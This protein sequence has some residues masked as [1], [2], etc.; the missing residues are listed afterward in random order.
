M[1]SK[2]IEKQ[3][4]DPVS[5][6]IQ[7]QTLATG[8]RAYLSSPSDRARK[9]LYHLAIQL[10]VDAK[11]NLLHSSVT[12]ILHLLLLL[13][14]LLRKQKNYAF[15]EQCW[16]RRPRHDFFLRSWL[17]T[18]KKSGRSK[19]GLQALEALT[20]TYNDEYLLFERLA[21][22]SALCNETQKEF[23]AW[24]NAVRLDPQNKVAAT[25]LKKAA[26]K[27]ALGQEREKS[28]DQ[29]LTQD[30]D[31]ISLRMQWIDQRVN[32]REYREA[33]AETEAYISAQTTP[34]PRL[35]R[36]LYLL[37]EHHLNFQLAQA[38]DARNK[39]SID[40]LQTE[41]E[42]L[43]I[44]RLER[45]VQ[46]DQNN[47]QYRYDLGKALLNGRRWQAAITQ[48]EFASH[49]RNRRLRSLIYLS[50]AYLALDQ[51]E[52]AR[53]QL[54]SALAEAE[55]STREHREITERLEMLSMT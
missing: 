41:L 27:L 35:E 46:R 43:H 55:N 19:R 21:H 3:N 47:L 25:A 28:I 11:K 42:G 44:T 4:N 51:P 15:I 12:Q 45:Q 40:Q 13:H 36:R 49:Q 17:L 1:M 48:L 18:A 29:Q 31:N 7:A 2:D 22:F 23:T 34:D 30:P 16:L 5:V 10:D 50:E 38:Q 39:S 52:K 20:S 32:V 37:K 9:A 26:E 33:I 14:S 53:F 6:I 24:E 8:Y 54:E